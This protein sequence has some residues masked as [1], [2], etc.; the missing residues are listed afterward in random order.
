MGGLRQAVYA[1]PFILL[2][3]DVR[4]YVLSYR[5]GCRFRIARP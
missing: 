5:V 3:E 1:A 4:G 2:E